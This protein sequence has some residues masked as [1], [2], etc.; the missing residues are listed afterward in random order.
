VTTVTAVS[1]GELVRRW[2]KLR[3][4]MAE[5]DLDAVIV[6][7]TPDDCELTYLTDVNLRGGQGIFML[8]RSGAARLIVRSPLGARPESQTLP[9]IDGADGETDIVLEVLSPGTP[10]SMTEWLERESP[11]TVGIGPD[12]PLH[13]LA[14]PEASFVPLRQEITELRYVKSDEEME[15]IR[16]SVEI[17]DEIFTRTTEFVQPGRTPRE[18]YG[19]IERFTVMRGGDFNAAVYPGSLNIVI[20]FD[21]SFNGWLEDDRPLEPGEGF[22]LE[23]SPKIHGYY[24]QL[25]YPITVGPASDED[26]RMFECLLRAREAG[27][28]E[29]RPGSNSEL[30]AKAMLAV[31]DE[32]GYTPANTDIGHMLGISI[33]EPRLGI[34]TVIDFEPGMVLVYHPVIQSPT[35]SWVFRGDTYLVTESGHERLN[36][37]PEELVELEV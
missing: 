11:R 15:F 26:K 9:W 2:A 29:L 4:V 24:S 32:Y 31:V 1:N 23:I 20:R 18:V 12:S 19:E 21:P 22:N 10:A 33:T 6:I 14:L 16:R 7:S 13:A 25:T 34:D 37:S 35:K 36:V 3:E 17:A 27:L 28:K 8:S 5:R 30:S